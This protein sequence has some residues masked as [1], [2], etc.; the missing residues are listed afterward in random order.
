MEIAGIEF[1]DGLYY[2]DQHGWAQAE[3][4]IVVQGLTDFGQKI[5]QEIVFVESPRIGRTVE[6]GQTL[7]SLESGKWVGRIPA[8]ASGSIAEVNEELEWEPNLINDSPFDGGWL[9]K[10]EMSDPAE[11]GNL[12]RADSAEF[13]TFIAAEAEKYKEL[14]G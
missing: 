8:L 7:L 5:A 14:L 1:P 11:L 3:G 10:I 6:Q 2:D 13:K 4:S 12:M 9:V